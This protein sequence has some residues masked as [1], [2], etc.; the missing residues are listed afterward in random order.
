[1][2]PLT[3]HGSATS[4]GSFGSMIEII[5]GNSSTEGQLHMGMGIDSTR[6]DHQTTG[7]DG[8]NSTGNRDFGGWT[9]KP[10]D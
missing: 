1:M 8:A 5:D 10:G 3:Y 6:N 2:A 4:N 9:H 7:I